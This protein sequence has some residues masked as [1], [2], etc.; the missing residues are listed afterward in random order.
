[1]SLRGEVFLPTELQV[2]ATWLSLRRLRISIDGEINYVVLQFPSK[3][4]WIGRRMAVRS[5]FVIRLA[6]SSDSLRQPSGAAG[7]NF[8]FRAEIFPPIK[9]KA[10]G[11]QSGMRVPK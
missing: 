5:I 10:D 8:N 7:G 1:V 4:R 11:C 2:L 6:T 9:S 3:L